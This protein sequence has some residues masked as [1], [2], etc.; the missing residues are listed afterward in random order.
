MEIYWTTEG[1]Q[2]LRKDKK[3]GKR[4]K[5]GVNRD[6]RLQALFC[7]R[8]PKTHLCTL[9]RMARTTILPLCRIRSGWV[10]ECGFVCAGDL[11]GHDSKCPGTDNGEAYG[12]FTYESKQDDINSSRDGDSGYPAPVPTNVVIENHET[13]NWVLWHFWIERLLSCSSDSYNRVLIPKPGL[14]IALVGQSD[15]CKS[16]WYKRTNTSQMSAALCLS[17]RLAKHVKLC[18]WKMFV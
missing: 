15:L 14:E 2:P 16:I 7:T 9:K 13:S 1:Y 5:H 17:N 11:F 6:F 18:D 12:D 8:S 10:E 4:L 3:A